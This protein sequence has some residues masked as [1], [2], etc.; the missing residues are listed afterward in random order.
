[1]KM[2][3]EP[4]SLNNIIRMRM[5]RRINKWEI[6]NDYVFY[7]PSQVNVCIIINLLIYWLALRD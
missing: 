6:Y 2:E 3:D 1:M 4:G 7:A 5:R